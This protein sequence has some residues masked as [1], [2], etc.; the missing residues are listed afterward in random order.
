MNILVTGG[1]G[2][3]G[4]P[5]I[6]LL[7]SEGHVLM[8][9]GRL[10]NISKWKEKLIRFNPE[11]CIHMAWEGLPNYSR[12][13][14]SKNLQYGVN[15]YNALLETDCKKII[16]TGSCW[17]LIPNDNPFVE[18]KCLLHDYGKY[19]FNG[20][21]IW[22]RLFYVYGAGQKNESLIP[23][24]ISAFNNNKIP[25]IKSPG[26][27]H[28]FIHVDDVAKAIVKLVYTSKSGVYDVGSGYQTT[29]RE[30]VA[31]VYKMKKE[32]GWKPSMNIQEGVRK[33]CG[34]KY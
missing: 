29:I 16:T 7:T 22:A 5:V 6:K 18:A 4:R 28:D 24:I 33:I 20:T 31:H 21:F 2:F 32:T 25:E 34:T 10:E 12:E 17:E 19:V 3:I 14:S 26:S 15:L 11:V 9:S 13:Q 23:T 27:A 1:T 8:Y 30:I